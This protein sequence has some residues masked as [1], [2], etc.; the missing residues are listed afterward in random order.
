M[1]NKLRVKRNAWNS[2]GANAAPPSA[3]AL[4]YGELAWE[5]ISGTLYIGKQI[6]GT[7]TINSYRVIPDASDTIIG[8]ASFSGNNFVVNSGAVQIK[9]LGIARE[10]I[11][12]DAINGSKIADLAVASEHIADDAV[13]LG[14]KTTGNYAA[15]LTGTANEIQITGS[16]GEGT[17]YTVGLPNDV[18]IQGNLTVEGTTTSIESTEVNIDDKNII[19]AHNVTGDP[20]TIAG[21]NGAGIT[22]GS[23]SSGTAPSLTWNNGGGVDYFEFSK[24]V[25]LTIGGTLD[26]TNSVG[27]VLDFGE[28]INQ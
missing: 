28:Y 21:L 2:T 16:A 5:N 23:P 12:A 20:A 14:T 17:A 1:A 9:D 24:A 4:T 19:L 26:S 27:S 8:A 13:A 10:E 3:N 18:V 15:S 6:N 7:G 22:L 11:A 25:K